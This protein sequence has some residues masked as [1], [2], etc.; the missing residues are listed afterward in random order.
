MVLKSRYRPVPSNTIAVST[1]STKN[2]MEKYTFL[3]KYAYRFIFHPNG[4]NFKGFVS[5]V[6]SRILC[7]LFHLKIYLQDTPGT[8]PFY[9]RN[10]YL[11]I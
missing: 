3:E 1:E 9:S 5:N 7:V 4:N 6:E 8:S 10:T 11:E 2:L